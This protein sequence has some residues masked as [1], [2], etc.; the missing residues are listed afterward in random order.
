MYEIQIRTHN[1]ETISRAFKKK[2]SDLEEALRSDES[3]RRVAEIY[4]DCVEPLVPMSDPYKKPDAGFLRASAHVPDNKYKGD[5]YVL[6]DAPYAEAQ[7]VG[8]TR[9][10]VMHWTTPG[11]HDHWN[12]HM[13]SA[14]RAAF[15]SLVKEELL[16]RIKD[17][18]K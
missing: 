9:G 7:F 6:Y 15:H 5:Y 8:K 13:S 3:K 11:T 10:A 12:R 1:L 2:V 17:G 14:D 16:K 18:Q 4:L